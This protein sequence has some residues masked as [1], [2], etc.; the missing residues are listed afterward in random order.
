MQKAADRIRYAMTAEKKAGGGTLFTQ[1]FVMRYI[2]NPIGAIGKFTPMR[3]MARFLGNPNFIKYLAGDISDKEMLKRAPSLLRDF[4]ITRPITKSMLTQTIAEGAEDATQ[5]AT[6]YR[7]T[8][9]VDPNIPL[10][11]VQL[12]KQ[13]TA[14]LDLPEVEAPASQRQTVGGRAVPASL[15]SDPIT[16]DLANLLGQ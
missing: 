13:Q 5:E 16:R 11:S 7:E 12:P 9:G 3:Y 10:G 4:G 15:I 14:S 2:F 8:D 6:R 1:A